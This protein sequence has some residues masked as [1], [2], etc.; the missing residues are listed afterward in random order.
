MF[1]KVEQCMNLG[2]LKSMESRKIQH[3]WE[4]LIWMIHTKLSKRWN[5]EK[6][7]WIKL[8]YENTLGENVGKE[9]W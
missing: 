4:N 5:L 8:K 9:W 6:L 1:G 3:G 2:K 7:N